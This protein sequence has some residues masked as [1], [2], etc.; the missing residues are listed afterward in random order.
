MNE[1]SALKVVAVR[2]LETTDAA[3]ATWTDVDRAWASRASAQVVGAGAS[4]DV[5]LAR[6]ADL[7]LERFGAAQPALPR[8]I[9]ALA[10]RPWVGSAVVAAAFVLGVLLDQADTTQRVNVLAPP[11]LGLL[12]WNL[13]VYVFIAAGYVVRYGEP[14][15]PGFLRGIVARVS[16]GRVTAR[17][18]GGLRETIAVFGDEWARRAAPL[19]RARAA[20][21]LHLAAAMLAAGV[22]AGL[23]LRGLAFEYRASWESTFLDAPTVRSILAVAYAPGTLLTG[24][25]VASVAEV[26]AIR[27]PAGEN[28]ARWLHLMTATVVVLV[29]VPRLLLALVAGIVER[30]RAAHMPMALDEPYFQRLLRGFR[31]GPARV[32]VFPYS[33]SPPPAAI[34]GLEA[35][36]ARTFGGSA[37]MVVATPAAY[38]ADEALAGGDEAATGATLVALLSAS[39]TPEREAHGAFLA[40]LARER[41]RADAVFALVDESAWAERW[42]GEPGRVADRRSA[43]RQ[44]CDEAR[45]PVVFVDLANPD[46]A[47][48]DAELDAAIGN[49]TP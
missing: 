14:A 44:V 24:F 25:P 23:Y 3:R 40:A 45:V 18:T 19:Y 6:R 12:V 38:G 16:G 39:A 46:L 37:A 35:I 5:F 30:R 2:A 13:A 33:F 10:W 20:R 8:A 47:A 1:S 36:V 15:T 49:R 17:G 42:R 41:S 43:W 32:R 7:A 22:L 29:F 9:R 31:G 26:A 4:P 48:I 34:A 11:V 21:I 28:A 27:A